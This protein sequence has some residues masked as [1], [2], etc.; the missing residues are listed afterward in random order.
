MQSRPR[1]LHLPGVA[2]IVECGQQYPQFFA[3]VGLNPGGIIV[4]KEALEPFV[5]KT[6]IILPPIVSAKC[7]ALR[8]A[9][10]SVNRCPPFIL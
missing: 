3:V 5:L 7:I 4:L 8:N 6:L 10:Q 9:G 1:P 2:R